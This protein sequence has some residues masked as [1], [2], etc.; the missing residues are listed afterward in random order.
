MDCSRLT[1]PD[2]V[3]TVTDIVKTWYISPADSHLLVVLSIQA[4]E[5]RRELVKAE[6]KVKRQ[7]NGL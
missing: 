2:F 5:F 6:E 4:Q 1:M 3:K 7:I